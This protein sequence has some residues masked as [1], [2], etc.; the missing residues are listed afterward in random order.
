MIGETMRTARQAAGLSQRDVADLLG[1]DPM[2]VSRWERGVHE[3]KLAELRRYAGVVGVE[4]GSLLT[5]PAH[6]SE[7]CQPPEA[8][9][10]A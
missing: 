7:P 2:T 1:C 3:P 5:E 6:D 4:F 10:A 9:D 8:P